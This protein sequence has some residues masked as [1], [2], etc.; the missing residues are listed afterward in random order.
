MK[1]AIEI[2]NL[3][4]EYSGRRVV[5]GLSF[6]V[7]QGEIFG[8]LGPNGSGKTTTI[9]AL[10][11]LVFPYSGS[12]TVHGLVPSD[13]RSRVSVGFMPEE[14]TYYRFLSPEELLTFYGRVFDIASSELKR[15]IRTLLSLVGLSSVARKPLSAFSKGMVQ[16]V[17]LAQALIN[18]PQTLILDEPT[19]GLDPLAKMQ[20]RQI[21]SGLKKQGKTVFFSSHELS[22]AELLCDSI[23][24]IKSGKALRSGTLDDVLAGQGGHSLEKFFVNTIQAAAG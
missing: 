22:E 4:V 8:F 7:R 16:K 20:L 9:K 3:V 1:N 23:V 10:L 2:A 11:G 15:R 19:T 14:A 24:I 5:D 6:Q 18:D 12:V 13:P 21:L 17:S